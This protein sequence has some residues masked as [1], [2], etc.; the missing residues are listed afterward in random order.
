MK[1]IAPGDEV[2]GDFLHPAVFLVRDA[3]PI[4]AEIVNDDI[5]GLIDRGQV[6]ALARVHQIAGQL[7][8]TVDSHILATRQ[9][10]HV[11]A[12]PTAAP[13]HLE[14]TVD[15]TLSVQ[16]RAD[17][18]LIQEVDAD[19]FENAG[20]DPTEDVFAGLALQNYRVDSRPGQQLAEK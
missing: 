8:L 2:A 12:A 18:R 16:A 13:E 1:A 4:T 5:V 10:V 19:L 7:R 14:A 6:G 3:R 20:P 11:D 17:A 9:A 15:H